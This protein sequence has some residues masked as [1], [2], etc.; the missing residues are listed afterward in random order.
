MTPPTQD[1]LRRAV[2][3]CC[4]CG[5][6]GPDDP[7]VCPA[8]RVWH[9]LATPCEATAP[10]SPDALAAA[11]AWVDKRVRMNYFPEG[12][13]HIDTLAAAVREMQ[14]NIYASH[15][16]CAYADRAERAEAA[17]A[18][19]RKVL[20]QTCSTCRHQYE[21]EGWLVCRHLQLTCE[22][23][24]HTCGAYAAKEPTP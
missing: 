1:A 8:C 23:M 6:M 20:C 7:G 10:V 18:E 17:L 22:T 4:T 16:R 24:G 3:A 13:E 14:Q 9:L 5:G 12:Y 11:L 15:A 2:N 19:A 21:S